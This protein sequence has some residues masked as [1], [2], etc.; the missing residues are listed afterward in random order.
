MI[1]LSKSAIAAACMAAFSFAA[2]PAHAGLFDDD[3][4]RKAILDLRTKI[5]AVQQDVNGKLADKAD[6]SGVL[7]LVNQNEQLQQEIAKL[8]GQ[9]EVLT[10][11]LAETQKRQKDFY[12]D[13]DTRLRNLE[14]KKVTVD[15]QEAEVDPGEQKSYEN[16]MALFKDGDYKGAGAALND[17]LRRFPTS[18][19]AANAQYALG[20]SFYVQ[21]DYRDALSAQ[22]VVVKNYPSSPRAPEA[23]LNIASCYVELKD[24]AGAKRTLDMLIDKYPDSPSAQTAKE[25][26]HAIK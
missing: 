6:K 26:L 21:S 9:I 1:R 5:E 10:N 17:F 3:E 7:D 20:N 15:G 8:R 12:V 13:L 2:L 22:Q 18:P 4:A 11:D 19:F 14:P 23:L 16:A 24:K 25:R